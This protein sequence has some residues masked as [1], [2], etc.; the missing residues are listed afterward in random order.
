MG[1]R[2]ACPVQELA[3]RPD[4]QYIPGGAG[5]NTIRVAQ[6]LLEVPHATTYFGCIGEDDFGRKM[7]EAA[8]KE[9]VNVG[10]GCWR[11]AGLWV[12]D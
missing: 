2:L 11:G 12:V 1:T 8:G 4:V 5:Q 7:T 6:W 10:V 9:G 3:A